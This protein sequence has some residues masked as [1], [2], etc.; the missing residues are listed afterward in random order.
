MQAVADAV[1]VRAPSLY[2]RFDGRAAL[3]TAIA[4]DVATE[5]ARDLA[6]AAREADPQRAIRAIARRYRT[7]AHRAPRSYELLFSNP[8]AESNPSPE[9]NAASAAGLLAVTERLVGHERALDAARAFTAFAHGFV[10]ME[11]SGA[12]RLGG[13]VD[14]AF[15]FGVDAL[16]RGLADRGDR[17]HPR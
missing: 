10:S 9:V 11:L 13:N 3:I 2:K 1:G 14:R 17:P 5:M 15:E 4:D 12:F 16:I 6:P 8:L 7:F